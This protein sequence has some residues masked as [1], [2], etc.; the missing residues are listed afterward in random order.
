MFELLHYKKIEI[1]SV[2]T[3]DF[4]ISIRIKIINLNLNRYYRENCDL[5]FNCYLS[6]SAKNK[7]SFNLINS[8]IMTEMP[9]IVP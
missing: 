1:V 7:F 4:I 8:A 6:F 2:V 3:L 9:L 5:L